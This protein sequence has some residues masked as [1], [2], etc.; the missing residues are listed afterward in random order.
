MSTATTI[1]LLVMG[2]LVVIS[3]PVHD[4]LGAVWTADNTI[5]IR[6]GTSGVTPY[7]L[8]PGCVWLALKDGTAYGES[9]SYDVSEHTALLESMV[10][11]YV[12]AP[13]P[14]LL[15]RE[16]YASITLWDPPEYCQ[17]TYSIT[18][19][20]LVDKATIHDAIKSWT[21]TNPIFQFT[22]TADSPDILFD[23]SDAVTGD[24]T[25]MVHDML[26]RVILGDDPAVSEGSASL[27]VLRV[28]IF[29]VANGTYLA[30][31]EIKFPRVHIYD[32]TDIVNPIEISTIYGNV[33][34]Q[35][36]T[37]YGHVLAV[38]EWI[39]DSVTF[40]DMSNP[41]NIT[42]MSTIR[43]DDGFE[44]ILSP[45]VIEITDIGGDVFAFVAGFTNS[46]ITIV[47]MT[48]PRNPE[49][50]ATIT[51]DKDGFYNLKEVNAMIFVEHDTKSYAL[52]STSR[53]LIGIID[54]T[55]PHS[56]KPIPFIIH[57]N[58]AEYG[59]TVS[60]IDPMH[61]VSHTQGGSTHAVISSMF[62]NGIQVLNVTNPE[63]I[64]ALAF[65][66]DVDAGFESL[67]WPSRMSIQNDAVIVT[68]LFGNSMAFSLAEPDSPTPIKDYTARL[69]T[70]YDINDADFGQMQSGAKYTIFGTHSGLIVLPAP[71]P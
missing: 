41:A 27:E 36:I 52:V 9:V 13:E 54:V 4:A 45:N 22:E 68:N 6:H 39:D 23:A 11:P 49:H 71:V 21:Y 44:G 26:D 7:V 8:E 42:K 51:D 46:T 70:I 53:N 3:I 40:Y 29:E 58:P 43:A 17:F 37:V 64:T 55:N 16:G 34:I 15:D 19:T 28:E 32:I 69:N 18:E 66:S 10:R 38:V 35:D 56:P 30:A 67:F 33:T 48:D 14:R 62:N 65:V 1:S 12:F 2:I 59:N 50:V 61:M 60:N 24:I 5:V 25:D 31:S 63:Y 47:N 20:S 57:A